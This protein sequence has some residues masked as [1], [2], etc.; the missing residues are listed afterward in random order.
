M[1][2]VLPHGVLFRG[3]EEGTIRQNLVDRNHIDAIIGLPENIF[4]GT[5]IPTTVIVLKKEREES[6]ILFV[7]ASHGFEKEGNKNVLRASDIKRMTD[8]VIER[9][10]IDKYSHLASLG[11]IK[12][13]EYNLN[14]PRYVDSSEASETWDIYA[15]MNGGIPKKELKQFSDIFE[16]LPGL[17]DELFNEINEDYVELKTENIHELFQQSPSISKFN[18]KYQEAFSGFS[19][20]L[21]DLLIKQAEEVHPQRSKE[22]VVEELF[23]R[24]EQVSL[25]DRYKAYQ[26]LNDQWAEITNDIE[27]IQRNDFAEAVRGVDPHYV[28]KKRSGKDTEVQEGWKGRV[29]PFDLVQETV[30]KN[31]SDELNQLENRQVEIQ[32]ELTNII[33]SLSEE[34]GEYDVLNNSNDKFLV[35]ET[36][37]QL[38]ELFEE[39]DSPELR[40]L[41]EYTQLMD[42]KAGKNE[43]LEF[44]ESHPEME[45]NKMALKK[46]GTPSAKG[47]RDY[48]VYLQQHYEFPEDS[49]GAKLTS[50]IALID[51]E[52]EI[53]QAVKEK[54]EDLHEQTKATIE[55]LSEE[56]A[57]NL[58]HQ[59]WITP[60]EESI[61]SLSD[62]LFKE[63]EAEL[64]LL[65]DKYAETMEDIQKEIQESNEEL[66]E[67]LGQLTGSKADMQGIKAFQNLLGGESNE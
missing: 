36:K 56:Q 14:I 41:E 43:L 33:E 28:I 6:D 51:E 55:N 62:H 11:E 47:L 20:Y 39:V 7:D 37:N 9:K 17:Y 23:N 40:I 1:T 42:K 57:T 30:L 61:Q 58:L 50:A 45:W 25:I 27:V 32:E 44:I 31:E 53:K 13:N 4:F 15:T 16:V 35:K 59:K 2:I 3:G 26:I 38:D 65:N 5:G 29:I 66:V 52:K 49:F 46:D 48:E 10:E 60:I 21:D 8:T 19:D 64:S 18:T 63:L 54:E 67:M 22:S 34:E 12:A 24:F